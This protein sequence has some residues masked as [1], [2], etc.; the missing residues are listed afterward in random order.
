MRRQL[1]LASLFVATCGSIAM[2]Q[3][4]PDQPATVKQ[5]KENQQDRIAQGVNSGQL[6]AGETTKLEDKEAALNQEVGADKKANGGTLTPV[7]KAKVQQQQNSLSKQIYADK[8]NATQAQYGNNVVGQRKE[9]QQDRIA[10]GVNSGQLT[11]GETANLENKEA[12]VNQEVGADRK[13]NGGT[14]TPAEKAQVQQ[15]QNGLSKQI[16]TDKHNA[17]QAQYGNSVVGQRKENQQ[18]RIAQG[19]NSGQLTAGETTKLESNEAALNQ[20]VGADRKANGGTLT[21]AEKAQVQQQ[22]NGLSKQIYTD[23]H[24][25]AQAQ[26][27]NSEVGQRRENQQDRI[28][29]GIKSG[30]LTPKQTAKLENK[31]RALNGEVAGDRAANGGGL[32]KAEKAKINKQQNHLSKQ[33]M[34]QQSNGAQAHDR[35]CEIVHCTFGRGAL[36]G[37]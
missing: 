27:G 37:V 30:S 29:Q 24:N 9:N 21:P 20:E 6:T 34:H 16:Y 10:Q 4:T 12:A 11:A 1:I 32:T 2:A 13:A 31:E 28:A 8:H 18:D 5:R 19:V 26:Y 22:Q 17:T 25:A 7:E 3:A 15:Q 36:R 14:L 33:N 23:K 35:S